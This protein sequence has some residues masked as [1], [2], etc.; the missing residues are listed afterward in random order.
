MWF[1]VYL[2]SV[3]LTF[4][5]VLFNHNKR[6][7]FQLKLFIVEET[8]GLVHKTSMLIFCDLYNDKDYIVSFKVRP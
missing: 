5:L 8:I 2:G 3:L 6:P 4:T 7:V 1:I